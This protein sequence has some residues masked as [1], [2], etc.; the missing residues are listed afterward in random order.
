M[1]VRL[2]QFWALMDDE[3]GP[4]YSRVLADRQVLGD[5]GGR[6]AT[7]AIDAGVPPKQVWRAVCDAMDVPDERRLGRDQP[8]T[9]PGPAD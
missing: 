5:L 1:A 6:T 2:S 4:A 8:P 9:K 7:D 3:F